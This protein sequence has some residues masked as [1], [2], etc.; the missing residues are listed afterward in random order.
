MKEQTRSIA[1][2]LIGVALLLGVG[3]LIWSQA[4]VEGDQIS[5]FAEC[6][7][8]GYP[9][10]ESYPRQCR[11]DGQTF[12]EDVEP[13]PMPPEDEAICVDTCGDGTCAEIVCLGT[14]CP[15]AETSWTCPVDCG[16]S[17]E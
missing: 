2:I 16:K 4:E 8:A 12:V 17:A 7:A 6:E 13:Q 1:M 5:S 14:G 3:Y 9:I 10:M 15:C 11:A